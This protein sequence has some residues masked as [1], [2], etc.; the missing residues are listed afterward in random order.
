MKIASWNVNSLK[1]RLPHLVDWLEVARPDIVALQEIKLVDDAFPHEE[2]EHLGYRALVSGQKTYNGVALLTRSK[3]IDP[4]CDIPGFDDPQRRV[5]AATI[6]DLRVV[7]LYVVNGQE[8]GSEKYS[9]KLAWLAAL[10]NWLAD[11]IKTHP[12][13]I[14]LGDFNIAP[15]D[16]DVHDPAA[17]HE[18]ILCSTPERDAL[19]S[20]MA[21][22]LSDSYRLFHDDGGAYSWWDYRQAAFR[23]NIGL[24]IDLVLM[25]E[26]L[27]ASATA[28]GIDREPRTWER[29]SDHAPVWVELAP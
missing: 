20:L 5:L 12:K 16:R 10:R 29:P 22:G 14:V 3:A 23:R 4:V 7:D 1:V 28:A 6:G 24:R 27:R 21:L 17:W 18:Q 13:L 19:R 8:V 2:I 11:E 25:S 15:D 9:Y 26:A